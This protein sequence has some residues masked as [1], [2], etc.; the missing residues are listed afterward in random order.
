MGEVVILCLLQ[1]KEKPGLRAIASTLLREL[2]RRFQKV[3]DPQT[4]ACDPVYI[5]GTFLDPR[6][7]ILLSSTQVAAAKS[8]I[9]HEVSCIFAT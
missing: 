1:M 8:D 4:P 5:K 3:L 7:R 6:Y 2:T 9:L